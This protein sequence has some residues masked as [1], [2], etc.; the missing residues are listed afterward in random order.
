[1][2]E[3]CVR[4]LMSRKKRKKEETKIIFTSK[5]M[6][7]ANTI[8]DKCSRCSKVCRS[9]AHTSKFANS[10]MQGIVSLCKNSSW[11]DLNLKLS[12]CNNKIE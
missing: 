6:R 5:N 2:L 3:Y 4:Y 11:Y 10:K 1:M 8:E 9:D 7:I 12:L